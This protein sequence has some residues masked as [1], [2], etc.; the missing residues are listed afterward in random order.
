MKRR[1]PLRRGRWLLIPLSLCVCFM[2]YSSIFEPAPAVPA[3]RVSKS[4]FHDG[5]FHNAEGSSKLGFV[6]GVKALYRSF[7]EKSPLSRPELPVPALPLTRADL[8]AAPDLSLW[9]LGHSTVLLKLAGKFWLTDPVFA[10]RASPLGFIGPKRFQAPPITVAELPE[11]EAVILSH[12]HYDHLDHDTVL[13]LAAKTGHFLAPLGVGDRLIAWGVPA[14]KVQQFDWWQETRIG[15]LRLVAT[16]AQHFS[17]RSP[18]DGDRTLWAS[19][20]LIAPQVRVFFSG[21]SG[22][23]SGFRA[24]G[25]KFG[26]F[27]VTLVENG[28]YNEAWAAIHMHPEETVQAH[29]DLQGR[30]LVPIHNGSF[31]LALHA[32]TDPLDQV[33]AIA[34]QRQVALATPRFGERL[35]ITRPAP[36]IAWWRAA[37]EPGTPRTTGAAAIEAAPASPL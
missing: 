23:F 29:I 32:W 36:G 1:L 18:F 31:D 19:W 3:E 2:A 28:A 20:V 35:D 33:S 16:P 34:A 4:L 6:G 5:R 14:D 37:P 27:D 26:P 17:G 30:H 15:E 12:D 7:T 24:I 10:E 9:R 8:L 25:E 13:A 11:I 21:D 22:Y